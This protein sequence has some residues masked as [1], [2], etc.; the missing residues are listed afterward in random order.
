M[1]LFCH[2]LQ[3]TIPDFLLAQR[4]TNKFPSLQGAQVPSTLFQNK[5]HLCHRTSKLFFSFY[6]GGRGTGE[7]GTDTIRS[8]TQC[9]TVVL[10]KTFA[11]V[12]PNAL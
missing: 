11:L 7:Q 3:R 4:N 2:L 6:L 5:C 9:L 1:F 12:V 8:I 10:N